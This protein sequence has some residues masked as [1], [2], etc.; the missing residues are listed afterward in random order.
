MTIK[1]L[2]I[3][4]AVTSA[5]IVDDAYDSTPLALD[6]ISDDEAWSNFLADIGEGRK[7]IQEIFPA[8]EYMEASELRRS[9]EFVAAMW[10]ARDKLRPELWKLLFNTYEQATRSDRGFLERLEARLN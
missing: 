4:R 6:I 2:L 7:Q 9:D 8:F 1:E 5:L 10:N 3:D